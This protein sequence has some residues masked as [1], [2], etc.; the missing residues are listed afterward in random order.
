VVV[1]LIMLLLLLL[2]VLLLVVLLLVLLVVLVVLVLVLL[3]PAASRPT[4]KALSACKI[5]VERVHPSTCLQ[6][7]AEYRS[8][9]GTVHC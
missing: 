1:V 6:V 4:R 8:T 9:P 3:L 7:V 2:L 5:R